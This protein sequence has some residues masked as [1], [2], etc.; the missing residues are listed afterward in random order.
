VRLTEQ[1]A[2]AG[3]DGLFQFIPHLLLQLRGALSRQL[4]HLGQKLQLLT[5]GFGDLPVGQHLTERGEVGGDARRRRCFLA[6]G[7]EMLQRAAVVGRQLVGV[8]AGR[9]FPHDRWLPAAAQDIHRGPVAGT[10]PAHLHQREQVQPRLRPA[11][12]GTAHIDVAGR[13]RLAGPDRLGHRC[14]LPAHRLKRDGPVNAPPRA[15]FRRHA[16]EREL[17][18]TLQLGERRVERFR[19]QRS[20]LPVFLDREH[21]A[22]GAPALGMDAV[23]GQQLEQV[24]AGKRRQLRSRLADPILQLAGG[25]AHGVIPMFPVEAECVERPDAGVIGIRIQAQRSVGQRHPRVRLRPGQLAD[26]SL[27]ERVRR[28]TQP[29]AHAV[30]RRRHHRHVADHGGANVAQSLMELESLAGFGAGDHAAGVHG[31]QRERVAVGDAT[32]GLAGLRQHPLGAHAGHEPRNELGDRLGRHRHAHGPAHGQRPIRLQLVQLV[33]ADVQQDGD[34][35]LARLQAADHLDI[36]LVEFPD[37]VGRYDQH[38]GLRLIDGVADLSQVGNHRQAVPGVA[39]G[40]VPGML[41][42]GGDVHGH[43]S[44]FLDIAEKYVTHSACRSCAKCRILLEN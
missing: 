7:D 38:D 16:E 27:G 28:R 39:P 15:A 35:L 33:P 3:Q 5:L 25:A 22:V 41:Q 11:G 20:P 8:P 43:L 40:G 2:E 6:I 9:A 34:E 31:R 21:G 12:T 1:L 29:A 13:Q 19:Q 18:E 32:E 26:R 10:A 17:Q 24:A 42:A 4:E 23:L 37:R 30:V 36:H 14:D 44:V